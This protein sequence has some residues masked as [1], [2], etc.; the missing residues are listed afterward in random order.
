[1]CGREIGLKE[2]AVWGRGAQKISRK[3]DI[4]IIVRI[5]NILIGFSSLVMKPFFKSDI[6]IY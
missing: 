5:L 3:A 4:G 1:M 2:E 6:K